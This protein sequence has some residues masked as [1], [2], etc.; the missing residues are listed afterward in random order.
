MFDYLYPTALDCGVPVDKYWD[1]TLQEIK[2]IIDSCNRMEILKKK[3]RVLELFVLAEA[4]ANRII[5][6]F[7][8][9]HSESDLIQPWN[10][11]PE[12]FEDKSEELEKHREMIELE[13]YK[14]RFNKGVEAWNRR[15]EREHKNDS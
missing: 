1:L 11:Y 10:F 3:D 15:F 6:G 2:D 8:S 14:A 13:N 12:L 5:Y 4:T 9:K 7:N